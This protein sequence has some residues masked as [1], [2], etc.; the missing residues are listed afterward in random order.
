[1]AA[2]TLEKSIVALKKQICVDKWHVYLEKGTNK[3]QHSPFQYGFLEEFVI[4]TFLKNLDPTWGFKIPRFKY[5]YIFFEI[6][7]LVALPLNKEGN[8]VKHAEL[9]HSICLGKN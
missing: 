1:M 7:C 9:S 3:G 8:F 4:Q 2:D 6:V 5:T